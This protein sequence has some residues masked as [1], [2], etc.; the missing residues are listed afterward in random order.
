MVGEVCLVCQ[1]KDGGYVVPLVQY[2]CTICGATLSWGDV[3]SHY[4]KHVKISGNDAVCGICNAKVKKA[5]I[6]RHVRE[7]FVIGAGKFFCGICGREFVD[8]GSLLVHIMRSH[9]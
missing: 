2:K 4:M 1:N 3:V 7:H 6:R 8:R 9:E 5:E